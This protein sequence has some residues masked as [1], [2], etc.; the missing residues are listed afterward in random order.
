MPDQTP[1]LRRANQIFGDILANA[2]DGV[3]AWIYRIYAA[4]WSSL[5]RDT[6]LGHKPE[7]VIRRFEGWLTRSY[8]EF[9][10]NSSVLL[11]GILRGLGNESPY[12]D[13]DLHPYRRWP[14]FSEI[15]QFSRT[16]DTRLLIYIQ[17][18]LAFG[19]RI[20]TLGDQDAKRTTAFHQWLAI[21]DELSKQKVDKQLVASLKLVMGCLLHTFKHTPLP[22]HGSGAI[23][24]KGVLSPLQKHQTIGP[25]RVTDVLSTLVENG[26]LRRINIMPDSHAPRITIPGD[27]QARVEFVPK[28]L[29]KLRSICCEPGMLQWGQ[30]SVLH[31]FEDLFKQSR[32][33]R[34]FVR[35][36]DQSYNRLSA[37][38][39]SLSRRV[40]TL[41]LSSASDRLSWRLVSSIFPDYVLNLL[42]GT[43]SMTATCDGLVFN[44]HKFAPM[45]SGVCFPVQ[46]LV[47][48][49]ICLHSY[50]EVMY[51]TGF[52]SRREVYR[53][54]NSFEK[55]GSHYVS[56]GFE[57]IRCYGDDI[58]VDCRATD[59]VI[60]NLTAAGFAVNTSKSFT[61]THPFRESCGGYYFNGSDVSPF[62]LKLKGKGDRMTPSLFASLLD[63]CNRAYRYGYTHLTSRL[64]T[65]LEYLHPFKKDNGRRRNIR[66]ANVPED[67]SSLCFDPYHSIGR[68]R[69]FDASRA[70]LDND[71]TSQRFQRQEELCYFIR[72]KV[73]QSERRD[74][75]YAYIHWMSSL[76]SDG[77][78]IVP[79]ARELKL[80]RGWLPL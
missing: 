24:Q 55:G 29:T 37:Q 17:S 47:Y 18:F 59:R 70:S 14:I 4:N 45:G 20:P 67:S 56:S 40:D 75:N 26:R 10:K 28:D 11:D 15:V 72:S 9:A 1:S 74:E 46:T 13:L 73:K 31:A 41:D 36:D 39:G 50:N 44:L 43:R 5:L 30:Q 21:E 71:S 62:S 63:A 19:K 2:F 53:L 22:H 79:K 64:L 78:V 60:S 23:A 42:A 33:V 54:L 69:G 7:K 68:L 51:G 61:G 8:S 49:C 48:L 66:V 57:P 58:I 65:M 76:G 80:V 35:L 34:M 27:I 6:P 3:D 25:S 16:G 52:S 38:Y 32:Y 12:I 77:K